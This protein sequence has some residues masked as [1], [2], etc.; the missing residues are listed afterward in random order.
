MTSLSEAE[1]VGIFWMLRLDRSLV[2]APAPRVPLLIQKARPGNVAEL[3]EAMHFDDPTA[4]LQRFNLGKHCYTVKVGTVLAAYGWITFD[5]EHIGELGLSVRLAKGEAYIWDCGTLPA[6]RGQRLYPALLAH[7]LTV[8]QRAGYQRVWIGTDSDNFPSQ[9]GVALVGFQPVVELVQASDG[10][11][12][13]RGCAGVPW[14]DVVDAH[15]VLFGAQESSRILP[16]KA[17]A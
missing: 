5:Q 4:V 15:H 12:W 17:S 16:P 3:A 13:S 6:Y 9:R 2:N 11:F 1:A 8:L 7:M 10:T 14:Q